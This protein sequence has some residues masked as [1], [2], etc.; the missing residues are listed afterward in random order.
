MP[1]GQGAGV[2]AETSQAAGVFVSGAPIP[3]GFRAKLAAMAV[4][5]LVALGGVS[6]VG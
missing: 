5:V 4:G 3:V 6:V 1:T 2:G